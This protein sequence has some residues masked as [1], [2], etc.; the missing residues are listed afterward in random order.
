MKLFRQC[1]MARL[2]FWP[3][4]LNTTRGFLQWWFFG[5]GRDAPS[6]LFLIFWQEENSQGVLTAVREITREPK[7]RI[8]DESAQ[9][10]LL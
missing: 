7:L 2:R 1:R 5:G 9:G 8:R 4:S 6:P 10:A 3:L